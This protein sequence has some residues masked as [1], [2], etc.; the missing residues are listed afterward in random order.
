MGVLSANGQTLFPSDNL[1]ERQRE[2]THY[3]IVSY[4]RS[5]GDV[6]LQVSAYGALFEPVLHARCA[7]R[8]A[9]QRH[10]ADRLQARCRLWPAGR[11]LLARDPDPHDPRRPHLPGRR[12]AEPNLVASARRRRRR[13]ADLA[14]RA[15]HHRRQWDQARLELQPLSPGRVEALPV[16]HPQLRR[17]LGPVRRLRFR[18]PAQPARELRLDPDRQPHRP[19]RLLALLLATADRAD[20]LDR[21]CAVQRHDGRRRQHAGR[22]AQGR[23]R[24]LFRPRRPAG[25]RTAGSRWAST[26][27]TRPRTT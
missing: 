8:S 18:K 6:D 20:R 12:S 11:R 22:H 16:A 21:R 1:D 19:R 27:S 13:H 5:Q 9:L 14:G 15:A 25:V 2:I 17:P 10:L 4:L 23:A 3:G 24:R 7:R 26:V